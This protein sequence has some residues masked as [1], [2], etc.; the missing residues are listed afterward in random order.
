[1]DESIEMLFGDLTSVEQCIRWEFRSPMGRGNFGVVQPIEK[2][3]SFCCS[4]HYK[5]IIQFSIMVRQ[6]DCYSRMQCSRLV[7]VTLCCP[8]WK[9]PPVMR[10]FVKIL[11]PLSALCWLG[12]CHFKNLEIDFTADQMPFLIPYQNWHSTLARSCVSYPC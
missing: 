5:R 8:L 12:G 6:Q 4:V 7:R 1:M 11:W 9:S 3:G 10:P 2:H